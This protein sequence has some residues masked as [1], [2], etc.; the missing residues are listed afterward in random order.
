MDKHGLYFLPQQTSQRCGT[1]LRTG[2]VLLPCVTVATC[3]LPLSVE[4]KL[5][6]VRY[7]LVPTNGDYYYSLVITNGDYQSLC[8]TPCLKGKQNI[9][10]EH[11]FAKTREPCT[12]TILSDPMSGMVLNM[13]ARNDATLAESLCAAFALSAVRHKTRCSGV[14][15]VVYLHHKPKTFGDDCDGSR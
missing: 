12:I 10:Y 14:G 3:G 13:S 2:A 7:V 6:N 9:Q 5:G 8:I 11:A 4:Y 1:W 15:N